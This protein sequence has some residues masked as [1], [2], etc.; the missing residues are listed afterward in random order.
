MPKPKNN[1]KGALPDPTKQAGLEVREEEIEES[2]NEIYQGD[3]GHM[4][5]VKKLDIKKRHGFFYNFFMTI[6]LIALLGGLAYGGYY[7]LHKNSGLSSIQLAISGNNEAAAGQE[8]I[9]KVDYRNLSDV[10]LKDLE[11]RVVYPENFV[12]AGTDPQVS[13][14]DPSATSTDPRIGVWKADNLPAHRSGEIEIKG[15]M[16]GLLGEKH[17]ILASMTYTPANFNSEF[18]KE[19]A[20]E[21][22]IN[23]TGINFS[24]ESSSSAL[25]GEE[26]IID[27]KYK[28][29][30]DS[31]L[32]NFR[33]TLGP[34]DNLD[35]G[36]LGKDAQP[37]IWDV[38]DVSQDEKEFKIPFKFKDKI[39]DNETLT[40]DA[41]EVMTDAA[42]N[43]RFYKIF[44]QPLN[45]EL[46]KNDLNLNV[47]INGSRNDQGIDFDQ[48]L[49]YSIS[50]ANKGESDM[51][52]VVIMAVLKSDILDWT[53]LKDAHHGQ[54]S[55]N[56]I[57]WSKNEIPALA[58]L[59]KG[60]EG[61]IDFSIKTLPLAQVASGNSGLDV[62]KK[63]E[64]DSYA[65]FSVGTADE[66]SDATSTPVVADESNDKTKSNVIVNK[67]NS[68]L[69][70]D[71][72]VRYFN[73]DNIAVGSGP[74]PPK[75]GQ[76]TSFRVFWH[77]TNNLH[78]LDNLQ[79]TAVLPQNVNYDGRPLASLGSVSFDPTTRKVT[80]TIGR[81]PITT[82]ET[83][84]EFSISVTPTE[85]D[86]NKIMVLVS[87]S[88]VS[89]IDN[90]TQSL[91]SKTLS[92]KTTRLEDDDIA[93]T[94][95]MIQ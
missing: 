85:T 21:T 42:G 9:Y 80:W 31:Y 6:F 14:N 92:A 71:E 84:A 69:K 70:L 48:T 16:F 76:T 60:E 82:Y 75:V 19:A 65:Q 53:S 29:G 22:D 39:A 25:V 59:G 58:S 78:E 74:L 37:G 46:V 73:S 86:R 26:N 30:N 23:D 63:Y 32:N 87:G 61:T 5:D 38:T 13:P 44:E 4:V 57:S 36:K 24:V 67:I 10:D 35:F 2:L 43:Q 91:I 40:L 54:I 94:D 64:V 1:P 41:G 47:I 95:G 93:N 66:G 50:Y 20:L 88:T 89:A 11:I 77:L 33:L 27:I 17:E 68:D 56:V 18:K 15:K 28:G 83:D 79:V 12:L 62:T 51:N 90:E 34:I 45:F 52:N 3:D 81:L 55:G 8:L 49:N 7:Y 72:Q